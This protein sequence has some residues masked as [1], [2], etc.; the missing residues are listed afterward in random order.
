VSLSKPWKALERRHPKRFAGGV[1]LWRPDFSEELPDGESPTDVWDAKCY[2]RFSVVEL[3]VRC[4]RKY[5]AYTGSRRFHLVLFSRDHPR[6]GDFVLLRAGDYVRLVE[7]EGQ[8]V[9][10][11]D[12][13]KSNP[14][15]APLSLT[16]ELP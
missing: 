2:K 4:E 13:V 12:E 8:L 5:R 16:E 15:R 6:A 11:R 7:R 3:F 10:A 14:Y 9:R 1:R